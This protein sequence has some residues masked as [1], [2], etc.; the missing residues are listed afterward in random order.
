[1]SDEL[2]GEAPAGAGP[3]PTP[4]SWRVA[5]GA[6][7]AGGFAAGAAA[8][9]G[10]GASWL[11][12]ASIGVV[13]AGLIPIMGASRRPPIGP[14][15]APR[16][17]ALPLPTISVVVAGR[18]EANVVAQLVADVAAQDHRDRD[19]R[20]RFELV[21]VDDR[22]S[23]GTTEVAVAAAA[24][25][26]IAEVTTLIR[27]EGE[28]LPDGKGAA[29]TAAQPDRCRG[30]VVLVLDADARI[31][32]GF[33]RRLAAYVAAGADAVTA[34]RRILHAEASWLAGAQ[35]D[36]QTQDGELQRGRWASGGCSEFRGNGIAI[37]RSLL[38][39]VGG[40]RASALTEDIDLS[41]R[42]AAAHGITVAWAIDLEV[43]EEPVRTWSG[44][45]RQRLRWSEGA[46]RRL[47]E[48]G[49]AVVTSPR[50][51]VRARLDF[52][53]YG[54]QLLAPPLIVGAAAGAVVT[55]SSAAA[56]ALVGTYLAAGGALA[57]DALRWETGR[58][59]EPL[60]LWER[61]GR[62][63]RAAVFSTI[64]LGAVPG[65]LWRLATRRGTVRYDKMPHVGSTVDLLTPADPALRVRGLPAGDGR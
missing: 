2:A 54:G 39:A 33:L 12:V 40:W 51:A 1:M 35:A 37:R 5:A 60:P 28:H 47:F 18:D 46:I 34:R 55:G 58:D 17:P 3:V 50:L 41:S 9:A 20:P 21:I 64:W 42:I 31:G 10:G 26:G 23:D 59:G 30:D 16:D 19:G 44:L 24:A 15:P 62:A 25:H 49:P 45:W 38:A 65:A 22:S 13:V 7:L 61:L 6:T 8:A 32:P 56:V 57:F 36:E 43:W 48:H 52:A 63:V 27:R 11:V 53:A 14:D 4:R 29:L